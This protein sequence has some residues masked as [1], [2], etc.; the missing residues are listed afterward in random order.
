MNSKKLFTAILFISTIFLG[1]AQTTITLQPDSESGKDA[2]FKDSS[3]N[4]NQGN[5]TDFSAIAW[6]NGGVPV[7]V[8]SVIDF[9][10][11]Q[12]PS[13]AIINSAYL[14]LYNNPT[15]PNNSGHHSSQDGPNTAILRR[16]TSTWDESTVTWNTQ[17]G[18]SSNNEVYIPQS[19]SVNQDY[20]SIDVTALVQDIIDNPSQ[21]FGF[22]ISLNTEQLYRCMIL[23]SS[24]HLDPTKHPKLV[25]TY[26]ITTGTQNINNA[27]NTF[28]IYPQPAS[29]FITIQFK[30]ST[31]KDSTIKLFDSKGKLV[32]I[33]QKTNNEKIKI[34]T[35]GFS[36][37]VYFVQLEIN[38][39]VVE[40][41]KI[42]IQ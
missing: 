38:G 5:H 29:D 20:P 7:L 40:S 16:I 13:G 27:S 9:D 42:I 26:S 36:K 10:F 31:I 33:I 32:R 12:I 34:V 11:S 28:K 6:T 21:S 15:S 35:S 22:M 1:S 24:D 17:P 4:L 41:D 23:A 18:T 2:Y 30:Q 14:S 3:P 39:T 8:R 25:I 37:G 19:T